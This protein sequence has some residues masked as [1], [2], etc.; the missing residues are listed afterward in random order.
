MKNIFKAHD[1]RGIY[2]E[3]INES[4]AGKIGVSFVRFLRLPGELSS[5]S[6]EMRIRP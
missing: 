2:P 5:H 4:I 3:V 1:I 6:T